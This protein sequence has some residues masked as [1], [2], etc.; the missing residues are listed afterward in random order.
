[1]AADLQSRGLGERLRALEFLADAPHGCTESTLLDV[2]GFTVK[3]LTGLVRAGLA[4]AREEIVHAG[5]RQIEVVRVTI[6]DA[7]SRALA[8]A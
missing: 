4:T 6:T 1:M 2:H 3:L 7:G 5:T 8:L